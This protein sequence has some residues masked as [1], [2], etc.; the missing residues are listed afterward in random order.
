MRKPQN[1]GKKKKKK[2]SKTLQA[3][4]NVFGNDLYK[5]NIPSIIAMFMPI[6]WSLQ[7]NEQK[8]EISEFEQIRGQTGC[9]RKKSKKD[10]IN[11]I[12]IVLLLTYDTFKNTWV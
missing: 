4:L 3:S 11:K 12:L 2:K 8:K 6:K 5:L 7:Q 9:N 1:K 10:P